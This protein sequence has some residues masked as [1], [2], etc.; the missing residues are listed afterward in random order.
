MLWF[1]RWHSATTSTSKI[2]GLLVQ[3]D[4]LGSES[5]L[6]HSSKPACQHKGQTHLLIKSSSCQPRGKPSPD[7]HFF[8]IRIVPH[9]HSQKS[10]RKT[11][12]ANRRNTLAP[13]PP[14]PRP[15][16]PTEHYQHCHIN[17]SMHSTAVHQPHLS[18]RVLWAISSRKSRVQLDSVARKKETNIH[19]YTNWNDIQSSKKKSR[20]GQKPRQKKI[21]THK[22]IES[23]SISQ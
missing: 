15:S 8:T 4:I 19:T 9:A 16:K 17:R 20:K 13:A 2:S 14:R 23:Q 6:L 10:K 5:A 21:H 18:E 3:Y 12:K 22:R 7:G 11:N 1:C